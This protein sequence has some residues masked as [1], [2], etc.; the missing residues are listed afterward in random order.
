[1]NLLKLSPDVIEIISSLGDPISSPVVTE[2]KL[3]T[4]LNSTAEEQVT[5][6]KT[7]LSQ[8]VHNPS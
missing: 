3:R 4:L 5:Q 8:K 2:R 1:M 7:M 6:I